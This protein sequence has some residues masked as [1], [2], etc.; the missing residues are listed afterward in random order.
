MTPEEVELLSELTIVIPTYNRPLELERS[1]EYWRDTPV[2]VHILDGSDKPWFP[3]GVLPGAPKIMYHHI[4]SMF[5]ENAMENYTR[6][7][8]FAPGLP[9]TKFSALCADEDFFSLSGLAIFCRRLS[10]G[11][12]IEAVVGCALQYSK[13]ASSKIVWNL[14]YSWKQGV[15]SQSNNIVDRVLDRSG[16][17]YS[18]YAVTRTNSWK[19]VFS[20]SSEI[21]YSH[22]YFH[23]HLVNIF[24][25]AHC[26]IFVER[27]I[28]WIRE[29]Q[30]KTSEM[31]SG[32][33]TRNADWFRD[34]TNRSEIK[35]FE[36]QLKKGISSAFGDN[37]HLGVSRVLARKQIR[38]IRKFSD[39]ARFRRYKKSALRATNQ[40]FTFLPS[41]L[42]SKI[43][44]SLPT[45]VAISLG[46]V[47]QTQEKSLHKHVSQLSDLL[48]EISKTDITFDEE[49]LVDIEKLLLKPREELRLRANI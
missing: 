46:A 13:D 12:L 27:H 30:Q 21:K 37:E 23:E 2:T 40:F 42:K 36:N 24:M 14:R 8:Q 49:E 15:K 4:P 45:G 7:M 19:K 6:R 29:V 44:S 32:P 5:N 35:T 31:Y 11:N 48:T 3:V 18:Y 9:T 16:N 28:C 41:Q 43:N 39:T 34:R 26:R 25:S 38:F 20:Q 17:F 10:D 22:I 1:I 47:P 33:R